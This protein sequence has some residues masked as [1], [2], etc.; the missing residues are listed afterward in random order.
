M[1]LGGLGARAVSF[2]NGVL[3]GEPAETEFRAFYP[4][5]MTFGGSDVT[6]FLANFLP[7]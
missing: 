4:Y 3:G 5:N 2:P 6:N 7:A 1:Q